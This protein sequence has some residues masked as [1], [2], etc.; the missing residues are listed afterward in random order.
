MGIPS[1][2]AGATAG[3]RWKSSTKISLGKIPK[4]A[5]AGLSRNLP[6]L[7]MPPPLLLVSP[8]VELLI[9]ISLLKNPLSA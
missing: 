3:R 7:L 5:D 4:A 9:S 6:V 8:Q 2:F 1:G